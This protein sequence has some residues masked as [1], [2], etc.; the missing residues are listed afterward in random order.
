MPLTCRCS[1]CRTPRDIKLARAERGG[2]ALP[3]VSELEGRKVYTAETR[4][5]CECGARRI[6][7]RLTLAELLDP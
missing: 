5:P 4:D 6:T 2:K 3:I 7:I 1:T